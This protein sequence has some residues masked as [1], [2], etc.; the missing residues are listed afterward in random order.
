MTVFMP[1]QYDAVE[2]FF[3]AVL[4]IQRDFLLLTQLQ[5]ANRMVGNQ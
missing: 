3:M 4:T 5:L 1:P 2:M